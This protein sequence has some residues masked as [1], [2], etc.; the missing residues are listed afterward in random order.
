MK[1]LLSLLVL[2]LCFAATPEKGYKIGD[3]VT[4][5][6]LKNVDGK[7]VSLA[8][9]QDAK[10]FI[11]IFDCN[12]C[13]YSKAYNSRIKALNKEF[14]GKGY[15]VI[16]I[17]PNDPEKSPG[18]SFV[19]MAKVSKAKGYQYPYLFDEQQQVARAFGATN[20]PHV[21][22]IQ[23]QKDKGFV[24]AYKGTID[25]SPRDEKGASD[26]YVAKA[27]NALLNGQQPEKAETKAI[28]CG[29]KWKSS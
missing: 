16:A 24:L 11:I 5:F 14:A 23:K 22:V 12:T 26:F 15:P 27:V 2:V 3:Q 21:F 17:N 7:M 25:D 28:G 18:D 4:D 1:Y 13:P 8:D 9:Y 10:G 29:I 20:T 6:S 19:E